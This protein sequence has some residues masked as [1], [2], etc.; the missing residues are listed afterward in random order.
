MQR[1]TITPAYIYSGGA[2]SRPPSRP[3]VW[4]ALI[5]CVIRANES[6]A[7][8]RRERGPGF[9]WSST[10]KRG[11][12]GGVEKEERR[13]DETRGEVKGEE[14]IL[15]GPARKPKPQTPVEISGFKKVS[16]PKHLSWYG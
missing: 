11:G 12:R 5:S 2:G 1:D 14:G 13:Q 6:K 3:L 8:T 7:A 4:L 9:L 15:C 16:V 10:R